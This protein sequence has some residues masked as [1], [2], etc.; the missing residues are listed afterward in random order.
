[1]LQSLSPSKLVSNLASNYNK[2]RE[3]ITPQIII[4][5]IVPNIFHMDFPQVANMEQVSLH[6]SNSPYTVWNISEY[7]YE[8]KFGKGLL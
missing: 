2:L 3:K 1:M 6:I 5:E 4:S 8:D 7:D